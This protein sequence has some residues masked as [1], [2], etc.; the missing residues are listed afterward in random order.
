MAKIKNI[1]WLTKYTS[2]N[3]E[4]LFLHGQRHICSESYVKSAD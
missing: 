3:A 4:N 2:L 1:K